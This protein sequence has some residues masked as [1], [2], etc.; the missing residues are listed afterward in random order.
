MKEASFR[1]RPPRPCNLSQESLKL[2]VL[3]IRLGSRE[4]APKSWRPWEPRTAFTR[5]QTSE[6]LFLALD[7]RLKAVTTD[8]LVR[9][10]LALAR[11]DGYRRHLTRS[12]A[13]LISQRYKAIIGRKAALPCPCCDTPIRYRAG[14]GELT[15]CDGCRIS[16][17]YSREAG[18]FTLRPAPFERMIHFLSRS[19]EDRWRPGILEII[20]YARLYRQL[21]SRKHCYRIYHRN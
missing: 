4:R 18:R 5:S 7:Q 10:A 12:E 17:E 3:A 11:V 14:L 8:T 20:E 13:L 2:H 15:K 9:A 21:A 16:L 6:K 1:Q 19:C